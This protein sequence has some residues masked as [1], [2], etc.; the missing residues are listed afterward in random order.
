MSPL[1]LFSKSNDGNNNEPAV[2]KL[3]T[4]TLDDVN[5][6][7]EQKIT[8]QNKDLHDWKENLRKNLKSSE[9]IDILNANEQFVPEGYD[10]VSFA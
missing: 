6:I 5:G 9:L 1:F 8:R 2:K 7:I 4:G 10:D 3:K